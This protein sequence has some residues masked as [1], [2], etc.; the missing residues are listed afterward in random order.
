M[1]L[2]NITTNSDSK[3]I[4][5]TI[6][7]WTAS[8]RYPTFQSGTQPS[9]PVPPISTILGILSA[10]KGEIVSI[11]DLDYLGFIFKSEGKG[12][13]LERIYALGKAEKD[14]IKR[15]ILFNN[16]LYLYIPKSWEKFL[17]APKYQLLLGRSCDIASV[18]KIE[19][20]ELEKKEG[21]PIRGTV[22]PLDAE[23]PGIVHALP[24]E[25]DY[26]VIPRV[27]KIVRPFVII[28]YTGGRSHPIYNKHLPYDAELE[29]GVFLYRPDM[30]S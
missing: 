5:V 28:P 18:E 8:F 27:P 13:D 25:F 9:L 21:V 26:S 30:F 10:A 16:I 20:I 1:K 3:M 12:N 17:R 6:K 24:V 19:D 14:I 2:K 11:N 7:S 15:E 4:R 29:T 22:V 23:L